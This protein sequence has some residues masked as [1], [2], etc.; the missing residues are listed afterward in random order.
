M[1]PLDQATACIRRAQETWRDVPSARLGTLPYINDLSPARFGGT[2][3]EI[4]DMGGRLSRFPGA[5]S[6]AVANNEMS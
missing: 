6:E 5:R 4:S 1:D 3:R 2:R